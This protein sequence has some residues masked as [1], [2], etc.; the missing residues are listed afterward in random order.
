MPRGKV[1]GAKVGGAEKAPAAKKPA[2]KAPKK[3]VSGICA[4][5]DFCFFF[6]AKKIHSASLPLTLARSSRNPQ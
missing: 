2:E 1:G 5:F 4:I 3:K 6:G